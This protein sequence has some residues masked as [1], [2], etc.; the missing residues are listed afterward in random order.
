MIYK[1]ADQAFF[2]MFKDSLDIE[3]YKNQF[4]TISDIKNGLLPGIDTS[5]FF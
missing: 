2:S 1:A 5:I 4:K 3:S